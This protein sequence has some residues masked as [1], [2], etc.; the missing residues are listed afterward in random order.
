MNAPQ[1]QSQL[2]LVR[3]TTGEATQER[4]WIQIPIGMA[5]R[6]VE[7]FYMRATLELHGGNREQ[8]ATALG[9]STR[10]VYNRI[11]VAGKGGKA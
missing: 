3:H 1:L 9:V 2:P 11:P 4:T 7:L 8:A 5:L 6:D 10:T